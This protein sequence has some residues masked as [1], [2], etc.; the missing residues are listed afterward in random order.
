MSAVAAAAAAARRVV[1]YRAIVWEGAQMLCQRPCLIGTPTGESASRGARHSTNAVVCASGRL[2]NRT[3]KLIVT[4]NQT[5]KLL[6]VCGIPCPCQPR[7]NAV[8]PHDLYC[9][10]CV[11]SDALRP[12]PTRNAHTAAPSRSRENVQPGTLPRPGVCVWSLLYSASRAKRGTM[13]AGEASEEGSAMCDQQTPYARHYLTSA[14][15]LMTPPAAGD[16]SDPPP[17]PGPAPPAPSSGCTA[18]AAESLRR[19]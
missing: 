3:G 5:S 17:A 7:R 15:V 11:T 18:A 6:V 9:R 16:A 10:T 12:P 13:M 14:S 2:A 19:G 8:R 1:R 4:L